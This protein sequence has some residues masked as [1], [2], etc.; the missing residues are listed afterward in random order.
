LISLAVN[1]YLPVEANGASMAEYVLK[2]PSIGAG[3]FDASLL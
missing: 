2:A 3:Y 1:E